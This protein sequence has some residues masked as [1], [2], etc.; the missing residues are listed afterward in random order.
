MPDPCDYCGCEDCD[1][2][3][4]TPDCPNSDQNVDLYYGFIQAICWTIGADGQNPTTINEPDEL[5]LPCINDNIK[6][7]RHA[8]LTHLANFDDSGIIWLKPTTDGSWV[9]FCS[10]HDDFPGWDEA[11]AQGFHTSHYWVEHPS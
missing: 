3:Q 11:E 7:S 10:E 9:I 1:Q 5:W 4:H 2:G 6:F 8:F